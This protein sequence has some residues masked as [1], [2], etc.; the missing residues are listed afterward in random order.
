VVGFDDIPDAALATPPLTTI[1]QPHRWKGSEA[2]RVLLDNDDESSVELPVELT[3]RAS[4]AP[5]P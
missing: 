1:K 2:V 5:A 3:I 4:T